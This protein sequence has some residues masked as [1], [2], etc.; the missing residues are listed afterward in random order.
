MCIGFDI[1]RG[2]FRQRLLFGSGQYRFE[3]IRNGTGDFRLDIKKVVSSQFAIENFS[4]QVFVCRR[5]N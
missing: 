4:P 3:R 1:V 5:L 2:F